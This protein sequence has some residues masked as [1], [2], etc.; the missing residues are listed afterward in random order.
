MTKRP[1][2]ILSFEVFKEQYPEDTINE[3]LKRL[4]KF[5]YKLQET[6]VTKHSFIIRS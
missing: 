6:Q 4:K 5:G 1:D 3:G 2:G